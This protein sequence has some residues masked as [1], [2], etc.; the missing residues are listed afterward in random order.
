MLRMMMLK[1][2]TLKNSL[3]LCACSAASRTF[4][5][6]SVLTHLRI[7]KVVVRLERRVER[8][9]QIEQ[10]LARNG[11]AQSRAALVPGQRAAHDLRRQILQ[12]LGRRQGLQ[13]GRGLLGREALVQRLVVAGHL[14]RVRLDSAV[15]D[16]AV[17]AGLDVQRVVDRLEAG[18]LE[19]LHLGAL[20]D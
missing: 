17:A 6:I 8:R 10:R 1:H 13:V 4:S 5:S 16:G 14:A 11:I 15:D 20:G 12:R 9:D 18:A 19:Q 7:A 2:T 3:F